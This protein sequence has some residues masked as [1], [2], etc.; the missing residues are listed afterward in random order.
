[1]KVKIHI[2][3]L[4]IVIFSVNAICSASQYT[5]S[6]YPLQILNIKPQGTDSTSARNR[7]YR[8][9]PGIEYNI[10]AAVVGGLYPYTFSLTGAPMGMTIDAHT[11]RIIWPNPIASSNNSITLNIVDKEGT[12]AQVTWQIA[13]TTTNFLFIDPI[14]GL[15]DNDGSI[16]KP[17]KTLNP[18]YTAYTT[19]NPHTNTTIY[20]RNGTHTLINNKQNDWVTGLSIWTSSPFIWLA[21]PNEE[22]IID[23]N[24]ST[25][26]MRS[27]RPELYIDG[28]N[29]TNMDN[30]CMIMSGMNYSTISRCD[31]GDISQ[32]DSTNNNQGYIFFPEATHRYTM[33]IDCKFHNWNTFVGLGS[34]YDAQKMLID[35]CEFYNGKGCAIGVKSQIDSTTI[36]NNTIRDII[37]DGIGTSINGM[38]RESEEVELCFNTLYTISSNALNFNLRG[39]DMI[40]GRT[41]VHRNTIVGRVGFSNLGSTYP[42]AGPFYIYNNIIINRDSLDTNRLHCNE[43]ACTHC[44]WSNND[45]KIT[46]YSSEYNVF[47]DDNLIGNTTSPILNETYKLTTAYA[48]HLGIRGAQTD[49]STTINEH[50]KNKLIPKN[51]PGMAVSYSSRKEIVFTLSKEFYQHAILTVFNIVG[52]KV[53]SRTINNQASNCIEH[54]MEI[55]TNSISHGLYF[56]VFLGEENKIVLPF[57]IIK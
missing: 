33:I 26:G 14:N 3:S 39:G 44:T 25:I 17:Y 4:I 52:E 18:I 20:F 41:Y 6:H 49:V 34:I 21:Y 54:R 35:G 5:K 11:G 1:V 13:V 27:A 42:M 8:A 22:V 48:H 12:V 28:I 57:S 53:W 50:V 47:A 45:Y 51:G 19:S 32:S 23:M 46:A 36:R 10:R 56:A 40:Q 55:R 7:I 15:D 30:Y 43:G 2:A 16:T 31:F 38:W 29:F 24:K 9:Y 37:G